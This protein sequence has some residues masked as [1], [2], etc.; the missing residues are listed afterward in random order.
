MGLRDREGRKTKARAGSGEGHLVPVLDQ[1]LDVPNLADQPTTLLEL[2]LRE[3]LVGD[4]GIPALALIEV[5]Q[6]ISDVHFGLAQTLGL[7][8]GQFDELLLGVDE[9]LAELVI[10]PRGQATLGFSA[11]VVQEVSTIIDR[12]DGKTLGDVIRQLTP[13]I[14]EPFFVGA[15][16]RNGARDANQEHDG[17]RPKHDLLL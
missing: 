12:P 6:F 2:Q 13:G 17:D 4:L 16:G 11:E 7:L 8:D 10:A 3:L 1:L 9:G 14:I 5:G 15:T